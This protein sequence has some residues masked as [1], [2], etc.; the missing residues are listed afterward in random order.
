MC[1]GGVSTRFPT[2]QVCTHIYTPQGQ[3][4]NLLILKASTSH[5]HKIRQNLIMLIN[6][7]LYTS[8]VGV[9]AYDVCM[10][11]YSGYN[12]KYPRTHAT[13]HT[14]TQHAQQHFPLPPTLLLSHSLI[15]S[16]S[17]N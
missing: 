17:Q 8:F 3:V 4:E 16:L 9:S 2:P 15:L 10:C 5:F 1:G 14:H 7:T 11:S 13:T 6:Y 12:Y